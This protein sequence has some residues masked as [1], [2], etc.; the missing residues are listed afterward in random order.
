MEQNKRVFGDIKKDLATR[1][2]EAFRQAV[3]SMNA[4]EWMAHDHMRKEVVPRYQEP[5][6][7]SMFGEKRVRF[8]DG[9]SR[10]PRAPTPPPTVGLGVGPSAALP[11]VR[12]RVRMTARMS[13]R[14]PPLRVS[15]DE[16][17][18]T[19]VDRMLDEAGRSTVSSSKDGDPGPETGRDG[20]SEDDPEQEPEED[21]D[22]ESDD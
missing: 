17:A 10:L 15:D 4:M 6:I 19:W 3:D 14:P 7:P 1:V 22:E 11:R 2:D 16:A 5:W 9:E 21:A 12:R 13:V 18:I 8:M 20:E